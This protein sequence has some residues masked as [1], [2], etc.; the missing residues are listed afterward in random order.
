M[1]LVSLYFDL[2]KFCVRYFYPFWILGRINFRMN[3]QA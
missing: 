1:E 3:L 2:R